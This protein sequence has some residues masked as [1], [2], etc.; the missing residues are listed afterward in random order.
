MW[1]AEESW[2][3]LESYRDKRFRA[4]KKKQANPYVIDK[5]GSKA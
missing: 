1:L 3:L 5:G 2:G 4:E